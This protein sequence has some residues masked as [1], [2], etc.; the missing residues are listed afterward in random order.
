MINERFYQ[1]TRDQ[2]PTLV[3]GEDVAD[4]ESKPCVSP[5]CPP[6]VESDLTVTHLGCWQCEVWYPSSEAHICAEVES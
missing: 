5:A 2:W 4:D 6:L 1:F 3:V